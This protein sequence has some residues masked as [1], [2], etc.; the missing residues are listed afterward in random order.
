MPDPTVEYLDR[1]EEDGYH[2]T[3]PRIIDDE[4][5]VVSVVWRREALAPEFLAIAGHAAL[6]TAAEAYARKAGFRITG[7]ALV[8]S[9]EMPPRIRVTFGRET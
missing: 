9:L 3:E 7:A 1:L 2:E 6:I 5:G 8:R 4:P